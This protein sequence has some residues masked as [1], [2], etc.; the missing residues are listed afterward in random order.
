MASAIAASAAAPLL[1]A[2][3]LLQL[4]SLHSAGEL[5]AFGD[6]AAAARDDH[7]GDPLVA[8]AETGAPADAAAPAEPGEAQA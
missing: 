1:G 8:P 7:M 6:D 2:P 3:A 4:Q 5:G